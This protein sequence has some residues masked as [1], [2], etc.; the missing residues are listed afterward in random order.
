M[1]EPFKNLINPAGVDAAARHLRRAWGGFDAKRFKALALGGLDALDMKDRAM[2]IAAALEA[3]LPEPFAAAAD[4]IEASLG[5]PLAPADGSAGPA[6]AQAGL[7]GWI[8]WPLGE[9]VARRGLG[10]PERALG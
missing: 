4:V 5:P 1:A 9:F 8:V 2:Q 6:K 10:D 7:S 3:T